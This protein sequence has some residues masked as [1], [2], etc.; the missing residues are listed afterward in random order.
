[1][2]YGYS[3]TVVILAHWLCR[4]AR[5]PSLRPLAI[6]IIFCSTASGVLAIIREAGLV[7]GIFAPEEIEAGKFARN[8]LPSKAL[9]LTGQYHNQPILC[10]AGRPIVLGYDFWVTSHGYKSSDYDAIKADVQA[11]YRGGPAA[12]NLLLNYRVDY[13]YIG[14]EEKT[15]LM[16]NVQYFE[17]NNRAV[18]RNKDITIYETGNR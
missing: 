1:M 15:E 14:P 13:I 17:T 18:F 10:L 9:F 12:K 7:H 4:I 8:S 16:P 6:L 3:V 11:M 5:Q 2:Y